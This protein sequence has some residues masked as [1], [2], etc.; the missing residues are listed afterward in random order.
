MRQTNN[1]H[2]DGN[3]LS[4]IALQLIGYEINFIADKSIKAKVVGDTEVKYN[5]K[6]WKLSPLTK[7]LY[8][9]SGKANKSGSYRGTAHWE[10]DGMKL[11]DII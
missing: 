6:V 5:G 11:E 1:S 4:F 3:R 8:A 7:E 9:K 2:S 10:F